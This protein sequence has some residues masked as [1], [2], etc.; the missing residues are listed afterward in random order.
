MSSRKP[1]E[2]SRPRTNLN[3]AQVSKK[4]GLMR[5]GKYQAIT[6]LALA[7]I[8]NACDSDDEKDK[9][10]NLQK[11]EQKLDYIVDESQLA[12]VE[13]GT[14]I[15]EI[16]DGRNTYEKINVEGVQS[17]IFNTGVYQLTAIDENNPTVRYE[18]ANIN[19]YQVGYSAYDSELGILFYNQDGAFY[20]TPLSRNSI[21]GQLEAGTS[22]WIWDPMIGGFDINIGEY[23]G[24]KCLFVSEIASVEVYRII[25]A[26]ELELVTTF[27]SIK[28]Q[29]PFFT[30]GAPDSAPSNS[31]VIY[32]GA[33]FNSTSGNCEGR[34]SDSLDTLFLASNSFDN[35]TGY[36]SQFTFQIDGTLS[37]VVDNE[38][39]TT[40]QVYETSVP[41]YTPAVCGDGIIDPP[42]VCD[43]DPNCNSTCD[44]CEPGFIPDNGDCIVYQNCGNGIIEGTEYCDDANCNG[45]CSACSNG[46]HLD[47]DTCVEDA[48]VEVCGN[49]VVEGS[50][51]CDDP[52]CVGCAGC[53]SGYHL[54]TDTC[55][56]D[57]PVE[58]CG[59][60]VVEGSETCDDP[61][62]VGCAG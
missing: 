43:G 36:A 25:S 33:R 50:E 7:G 10:E 40:R 15:G 18:I 37:Y 62:C 56:E 5:V 12:S 44:G 52:N 59:N 61:N 49:G 4:S 1:K 8:L 23:N 6:T 55:V 41:I 30:C 45:D 60:G 39:T 22:T 58:V 2:S 11:I 28:D 34:L 54:E 31:G 29:S 48:P 53:A 19:N 46:Y 26:T 47:V 38:S 3:S 9:G 16:G 42:E 21:T 17:T 13:A 24:E 51:T 57:A 27:P 20:S 35:I 14:P 32:V